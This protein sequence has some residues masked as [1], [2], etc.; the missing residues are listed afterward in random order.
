MGMRRIGLVVLGV[1]WLATA[2]TSAA[3]TPSR[4][5]DDYV[6][7]AL[8]KARLKFNTTINTGHVGVNAPAIGKAGILILSRNSFLADGSAAVADVVRLDPGVNAFDVFANRALSRLDRVTIRGTGPTAFSPLP[9][10]DPLPALPVFAPGT[11][12]VVVLATQTITL[13]PG[14]YGNVQVQNGGTLVLSGGTYEFRS[15]RTGR[16][17]KILVGGPST[18]NVA[19]TM[20]IGDASTF[21]P[22]VPGLGARQVR[23]NVGGRLARFGANVNAA[24]DLYAP[25]GHVRFGRSF[26]G[27][28]RFVGNDIAT[29]HSIVLTAEGCGDGILAAGEQCDDGNRTPC[30]GCSA[31]CQTERCGD[32][33]ACAGQGEQC[34]D[35]NI[36]GCDGCSGT[37]QT[38]FC[39]DGV[40][41]AGEGEECDPP[42]CGVCGP[43][44]T[45]GPECGDGVINGA[46]GETCDDGNAAP[47]DGCSATCG[48]ESC[49]DGVVCASTGESCDPPAPGTC[50]NVCVVIAPVM[51]GD[52]N[53]DPGEACDDNNNV[54][55][56]GC[57]ACEI[58]TC[59]DGTTCLA[60]G[61]TCDDGNTDACDGCSS[62]CQTESC[63]DGI[64]CA[65]AGETCD[66]GNVD[67]CDG[68]SPTCKTETCGDG[69]LCTNQGET[70]DDGNT[71]SCDGCSPTCQDDRCG[72]GIT[73]VNQNEQ[74]DPPD[75][76][77]CDWMCHFFVGG[78]TIFCTFD[79]ANYGA[80]GGRLNDPATGFVSQNPSILPVTVGVAGDVSVT[81]TDQERLLCFL[82][83]TGVEAALCNGLGGC[84]GDM[85]INAC[86]NP[87]IL[88]PDLGFTSSGGQGGGRLTGDAIALRLSVALSDLGVTPGGLRSWPL[89]SQFC[90]LDSNFMFNY[91]D[92]DPDIADGSRTV[93][94]L[95]TLA[96]QALRDPLAF[97]SG[98][99]ITR[100]EI[101]NALE[102]VSNGFGNCRSMC[103]P[104]GAFLE[105]E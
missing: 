26:I 84:G 60:L 18:I 96:D 76:M 65:A 14:A 59:G 75:G 13:P 72:D 4:D 69:T 7:F 33:V 23:V 35:G 101:A 29:D 67:A 74:C 25:Q 16:Q 3:Q 93:A 12:N 11:T 99:P 89:V 31:T 48:P 56:D 57:T 38:E 45:L 9:L 49:G 43:N 47:C 68:C 42:V 21:G 41:C 5:L 63:G 1:L 15:L 64:T 104:S 46:C 73:C 44:C 62:T 20:R 34:D 94:D 71:A 22:N 97:P 10:I 79:Q 50:S 92:V 36:V 70:C 27:R 51:C 19:D 8:E 66:D 91:W 39:G 54:P 40:V 95:L 28:G 30:D 87:P 58:D 85:T 86:T 100:E 24:L 17:T 82:P 55:C 83:T 80:P 81:V 88:D 52:G 102:A 105:L 2:G 98:D 78:P 53:L 32:G 61:E 37:C 6:V 90:T 103:S 77:V